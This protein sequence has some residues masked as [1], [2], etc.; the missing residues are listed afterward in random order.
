MT[1]WHL[2]NTKK[3][4]ER[5]E[6]TTDLFSD[7]LFSEIKKK[8]RGATSPQSEIREQ[9]AKL[10]NKPIPYVC[11]KTKGW[12]LEEMVDVYLK[13]SK[14]KVNPPALLNKLIRKK[15]EEIKKQLSTN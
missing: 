10:L 5:D 12:M 2:E 11:G 6:P 15:N 4:L 14:W 9:M 1:N 13:A 3:Q 7:R 8:K